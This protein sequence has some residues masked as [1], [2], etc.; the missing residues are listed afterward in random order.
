MSITTC[1]VYENIPMANCDFQ[2]NKH[3]YF[4]VTESQ[5]DKQ[6]LWQTTI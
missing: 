4:L 5:K 3:G 1:S 2:P 6:M